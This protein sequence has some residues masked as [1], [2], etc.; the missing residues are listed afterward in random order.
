MFYLTKLYI[1]KAT[2]RLC[3]GEL[4]MSRGHMW[5]DTDKENGNIRR[6]DHHKP[7]VDRP[8]IEPGPTKLLPQSSQ[9]KA[10]DL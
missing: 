10:S 3:L 2:G 9:K 8:G 6:L 7:H 5:N 4:N 1:S